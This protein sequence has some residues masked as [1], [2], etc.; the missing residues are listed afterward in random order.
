MEALD[1]MIDTGLIWAL[2]LLAVV[3]WT[4]SDSDGDSTGETIW[5]FFKQQADNDGTGE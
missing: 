4:L 5:D 3:G 2:A 1:Y